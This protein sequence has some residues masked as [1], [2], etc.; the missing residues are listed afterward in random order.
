MATF[1]SLTRSTGAEKTRGATNNCPLGT[2]GSFQS[3]RS[4]IFLKISTSTRFYPAGLQSGKKYERAVIFFKEPASFSLQ[5]ILMVDAAIPS[6]AAAE[7]F[8]SYKFHLK[9]DRNIAVRNISGL[10]DIFFQNHDSS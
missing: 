7:I 9:K 10:K 8:I 2:G 6:T 1:T 5:G 4:T 3:C